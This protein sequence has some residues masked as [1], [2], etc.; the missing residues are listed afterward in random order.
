M[1]DAAKRPI[2][3]G[4]VLGGVGALAGTVGGY[5]IRPHFNDSMPD[6]AVALLEDALA[7]AGGAAIVALGASG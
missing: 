2:L 4:A 5:H 1:H 7:L 6:V 3:E